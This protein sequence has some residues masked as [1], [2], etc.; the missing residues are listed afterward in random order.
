[1]LFLI[2]DPGHRIF[3]ARGAIPANTTQDTHLIYEFDTEKRHG[4]RG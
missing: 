1:M 3:T 4:L 2:L